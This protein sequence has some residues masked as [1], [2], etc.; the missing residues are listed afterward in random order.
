MTLLDDLSA[1]VGGA[2][3]KAGLDPALGK[4]KPADRPDLAQFQCNGALVAAKAVRENPR[5]LAERIKSILSDESAF[6]EIAIAGP[7]FINFKLDDQR[8]VDCVSETFCAGNAPGWRRE[9]TEKIVVDYGGP[10][11]AKPLHVGHLRSAIIG[12]SIKKICRAAGD[13]AVGDIHLGD[14]GLQMGQLISELQLRSPELPYFDEGASGPLPEEAPVSFKDLEEIYPAASAACKADPER[15]ELAR[16]ATKRLQAGDQGYRA[17]W[18]H[19]VDLSIAAMRRNY[20]D[21]GVHFDL[22]KGE[23]DVDPLIPD[24]ARDLSERGILETSDGAKIIRIERDD[25]KKD[26]PPIIFETSQGAAGYHTTDIATVVD[27]RDALAPDRILYVVDARQRLHFEQVYR[28]VD[29]AGYF[30]EDRLEHLWFGTMN[31][32]DGKP[33]K[34]REGGTLK[35]RDLIVMVTEKARNRLAEND[36]AADFTE[37]ETEEIAKQVGVAALKF[38]DLSNPRTSDYIFDID[39]FTS[40]EGKTGPYLL[41]ARARIRSV[42]SKAQ[43][44]GAGAPGPISISCDEE[45]ALALSLAAYPDIFRDAYQKRLPHF[46]CEAAFDLAQAFSRFYAACRISDEDNETLRASRLTLASTVGAALDTT[47]ELLGIEAPERM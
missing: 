24:I 4:V 25:D 44:A 26:M 32:K 2:F 3:E 28:A 35:L 40:F 31:G 45:R 18:R 23:S 46:L 39:R 38:A 43:A 34:T 6:S 37:T 11:V 42:L 27:R 21:L 22:W 19:F 29:R 8:L 12:E 15:A 41:Y 9:Q 20:D 7:G 36:L 14:W 30:P 10:N 17:L 16:K 13:D 5:A 33:F 47:F 1:I